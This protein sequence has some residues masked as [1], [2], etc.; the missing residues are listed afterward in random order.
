MKVPE[1]PEAVAWRNGMVL[2]PRHFQQADGRSAVLA[3][4]AGLVAEP[5]SWGFVSFRLDET[6]L[7]SSQLNIDCEGIFPGGAPFRQRRMTRRLGRAT[8]A[9]G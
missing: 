8:T 5:W 1:I 9:I 4:L 6:A 3:H 7:A 2:E